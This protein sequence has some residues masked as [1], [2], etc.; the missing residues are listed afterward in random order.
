MVEIIT[1][2][3]NELRSM[4]RSEFDAAL[5]AFTEWKKNS[6]LQGSENSLMSRAEV[7]EMFSVSLP[8]LHSWMNS[9]IIPFHRIG[10]RTFFKKSEV[11]ESLTK[12]K[13]RKK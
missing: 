3:K 8:T 6:S 4:M 13:I 10:G 2:E 9:G 1:I 12:I 7:A 11:I 5:S